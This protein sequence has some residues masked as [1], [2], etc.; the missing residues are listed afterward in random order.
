MKQLRKRYRIISFVCIFL[1][2]I[3]MLY[4]VYSVSTYG[5][6]WVSRPNNIRNLN[7]EKNSIMGDIFDR[8]GHLLATSTNEGERKYASN[9]LLRSAM[10]H[11][12]GDEQG[13]IANGVE[14]FHQH[15]LLDFHLTLGERIKNLLNGVPNKGD[16]IALTIDS[17]L[18]TAIVEM[19]KSYN[20]TKNTGASAVVMN[21]KTGEILA[22]V[23]FPVFD[24]ENMS[25]KI[26]DNPLQPFWNRATQALVPPGSIFKIITTSSALDNINNVTNI[27]FN[28]TGATRVGETF[29]TD[30]N[31]DQHNQISLSKAFRLSCNNTFAQ[32]ALKLQ[33]EKLLQTAK[34]FG[35]NTHFLFRDI[36][37][38][39][40]I[41]PTSN[42]SQFEI[43]W[44][45]VGQ[46]KLLVTPVHMCMIASAIANN[47]KMM[48]P[49]LIGK[50][51]S[52][53]GEIRLPFESTFFKQATSSKNA[54]IIKEYMREVVEN[55]TATRANVN[56]MKIHGK[57][58]S[59][60]ATSTT[61]HAWFVGF[62]A[63]EN[64]PIAV[65]VFVEGGNIG[66][67]VA[68]PVAHDIFS[69]IKGH[70]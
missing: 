12:L 70:Y 19:F 68:A 35:F 36:V 6:R 25:S 63:Q 65:S 4:G 34:E 37:L 58:G 27:T 60:E 42:R 30:Y 47:G 59:A 28:C 48:E 10:V 69:Y 43:A 24:P 61:T 45:G 46:S 14:D 23:S 64:L 7:A 39:D 50:I 3:A 26:N 49:R 67:K 21:Y 1:L 40:S 8:N 51:I 15:Y 32:I 57:T 2:S 31:N 5:S 22:M 20:A 66:G 41:Y 16:T 62:N 56:G 52:Q 38:E 29:I 33:D 44:T 17:K 53:T 9:T 13:F 55:G 18:Q 54:E 11:I